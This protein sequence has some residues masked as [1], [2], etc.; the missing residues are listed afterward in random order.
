MI[1]KLTG[2]VVDLCQE[3]LILEVGGVG[4]NVFTTRR[5]IDSLQTG[6]N[7][8]LYIEHYF[9]EN[10]NKLYGF[11]CKKSQEVARMLS[12]VKGINYKIALSLLNH[13]ELGELILAIQN[14]DESRLKIK[15][16]GEKL[17][18]RIITETYED[19]S[20]LGTYIPG[21]VSSANINRASE[22]V[23]ALVKLGFQHKPSHKVVMEI[24]M[25]HPTIEI[26]ELITLALKM[27]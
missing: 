16:I 23:S 10:A 12:K 1:G 5:L 25:N 14:K 4:Y 18:K 27:L 2:M 8:S 19:F 21:T 3:S 26:A 24:I 13:L 6:Q 20:K 22:A 15:G 17:V 9:S 11:E 7:L